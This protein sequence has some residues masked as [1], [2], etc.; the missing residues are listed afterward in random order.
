MSKMTELADRGKLIS[1]TIINVAEYYAGAHKSKNK[2]AVQMAKDYI[3]DFSVLL[4]DEQSAL[5][6]GKL[7]NELRTN[8]IGDRDLYIASIALANNQ[9]LLT[10][11]V[12][13]FERVPGLA[14]ESW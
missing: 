13:H 3:R 12:K 11:N 2:N 14:V 4:L 5:A 9:T 6:W 8:A 7:Y 10:R 1:T